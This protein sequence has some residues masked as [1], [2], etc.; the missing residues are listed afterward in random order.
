LK[1]AVEVTKTVF[2]IFGSSSKA[3]REN[4]AKDK[5][6]TAFSSAQLAARCK[7]CGRQLRFK[8]PYSIKAA[9]DQICSAHAKQGQHALA[10]GKQQRLFQ[11]KSRLEEPSV[12]P[13]QSVERIAA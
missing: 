3:W 7:S 9:I 12:K 6:P 4:Y 5:E 8:D 1:A 11:T 13:K 2:S 10:D